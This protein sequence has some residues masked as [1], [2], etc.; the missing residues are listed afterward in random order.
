MP[1][2]YG[3]PSD[4]AVILEGRT[5]QVR[6]ADTLARFVE[7][8]DTKYSIRVDT[9]NPVYAVYSLRLEVAQTWSERAFPASAIR[10]RFAA[11]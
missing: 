1:F 3:S 11:E 5:E 7:S 2:T 8:Y 6:D 9:G 10:W 4:D